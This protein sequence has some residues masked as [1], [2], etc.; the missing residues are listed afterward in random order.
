MVRTP[1]VKNGVRKGTWTKEEDEKLIAY[2]TQYDHVNWRQ[3]PKYAGLARCGKSCRLR[4][5]N[6]LRPNVKRGNYTPEEDEIIIKMH[7]EVGN[8]WSLISAKLPGRTDNEIK[9]HWHTHLKK[10]DGKRNP[11]KSQMMEERNKIPWWNSSLSDTNEFVMDAKAPQILE[12][13]L[14]SSALSTATEFSSTAEFS[15]VGA[16]FVATSDFRF[17]IE[18]R[19]ISTESIEIPHENFWVEPFWTDNSSNVQCDSSRNLMDF[20][21]VPPYDQGV[22]RCSDPK[23][24][25]GESKLKLSANLSAAQSWS[26]CEKSLRSHSSMVVYQNSRNTKNTKKSSTK[27]CHVK[28]WKLVLLLVCQYSKVSLLVPRFSFKEQSQS[29]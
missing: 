5:L 18:D 22:F 23:E 2:V 28:I 4:W 12:S 17:G 10:R 27:C 11:G 29:Y 6:Y 14:V 15:L 21:F 26:V 16:D 8:K 25:A 9:N 24:N 13:T 3:L 19:S 7:E 20:E 1:C